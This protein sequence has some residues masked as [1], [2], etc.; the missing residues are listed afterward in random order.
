MPG[1][2]SLNNL[3]VALVSLCVSCLKQ[4]L[5]E[6]DYLP[7][8]LL[9]LRSHKICFVTLTL[10]IRIWGGSGQCTPPGVN[11]INIIRTNFSYERHFSSY[12]L[13]LLK[14]LYKK[15]ARITLMKLTTVVWGMG[16]S[17]KSQTYITT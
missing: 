5:V 9:L 11:F 16:R 14:I 13:A 8:F 17:D 2:V 1:G 12:V 4:G 10:H 3:S 15:H 6:L 7:L